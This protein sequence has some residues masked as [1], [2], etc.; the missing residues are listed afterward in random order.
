MLKLGKL[1]DSEKSWKEWTTSP[2]AVE[3]SAKDFFLISPQG[4]RNKTH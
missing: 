3:V 4:A 1:D 2:Q